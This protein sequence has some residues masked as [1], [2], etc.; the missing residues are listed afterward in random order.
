MASE[1]LVGQY[2]YRTGSTVWV[3]SRVVITRCD[4]GAVN[5]GNDNETETASLV[6]YVS[7]TSQLE[8]Q[9]NSPNFPSSD[10]Y[11]PWSQSHR[12]ILT[13]TAVS[14]TPAAAWRGPPGVQL[15]RRMYIVRPSWTPSAEFC[16]SIVEQSH[17]PGMVSVW[18][19][20]FRAASRTRADG[21][22]S[23]WHV[24]GLTDCR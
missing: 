5:N 22:C 2:H 19:G 4:V 16:I 1:K 10:Y 24:C 23:V 15:V 9:R 12:R 18:G 8:N 3:L 11:S 13:V 6:Y 7:D 21:C 14:C 20:C 17:W